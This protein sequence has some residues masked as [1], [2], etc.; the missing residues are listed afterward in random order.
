MS[1]TMNMFKNIS[2]EVTC[3]QYFLKDSINNTTLHTSIIILSTFFFLQQT[4]WA[5]FLA[6]E[7][8]D[9]PHIISTVCRLSSRHTHTHTHT[10]SEEH[11]EQWRRTYIHVSGSHSLTLNLITSSIFA[12]FPSL[13][14]LWKKL[15]ATETPSAS[16]VIPVRALSAFVAI[17]RNVPNRS[18]NNRWV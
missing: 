13:T 17:T 18:T 1:N 7:R 9:Q 14:Q 11:S 16:D 15:G 4:S 12:V 10:Q 6:V 2:K 8:P 3:T 5:H